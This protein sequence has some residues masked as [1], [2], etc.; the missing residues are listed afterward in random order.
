M[1]QFIRGNPEQPTGNLL[2]FC[3]VEGKNPIQPEA[4]ILIANA[5]VSFVSA[6]SGNF[7]VVLFPPGSLFDEEELQQLIELNDSYDVIELAEFKIPSDSDENTYIKERLENLNQQIL[8][9]VEM[10]HTHI[11][12]RFENQEG[13][14]YVSPARPQETAPVARLDEKSALDYLQYLLIESNAHFKINEGEARENI[15]IVLEYLE[16]RHP[17]YDVRNLKPILSR[18]TVDNRL[19]ELYVRKF[20]AV[21]EE[22]Y[23]TAARLKDR[24]ARMERLATGIV[25]RQE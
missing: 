9:Y 20:R 8:E 25:A 14:S 12:S 2:A 10:C 16:K 18:G 17:Q 22:D 13:E 7:P 24:I 23:E 11:E 15:Q 6:F 19:P 1:L 5:V 21:F 3:T 4:R